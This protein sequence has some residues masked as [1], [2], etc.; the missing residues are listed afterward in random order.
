MSSLVQTS[1][2][3]WVDCTMQSDVTFR[4]PAGITFDV[5][6]R[7]YALTLRVEVSGNVSSTVL[8]AHRQHVVTR[9]AN[10][11]GLQSHNVFLSV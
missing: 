11:K 5:L 8:D 3:N 2:E 4:F 1:N 10:G 9:G 6:P 7:L